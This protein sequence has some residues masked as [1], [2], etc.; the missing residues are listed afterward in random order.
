[1]LAMDIPV[2]K[3]PLHFGIRTHIGEDAKHL[4]TPFNFH[5]CIYVHDLMYQ[6]KEKK[7]SH[8]STVG[9]AISAKTSS[10]ILTSTRY[11]LV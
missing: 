4:F 8:D 7:V 1:M 2:Y 3:Y 6:K 11:H 10:S 5:H 9:Y